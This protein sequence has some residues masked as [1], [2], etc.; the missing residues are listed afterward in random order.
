MQLEKSPSYVGTEKTKRPRKKLDR[1][2]RDAIAAQEAGM[3]YGQ[4]KVQH[5]HTPDEDEEEKKE[6]EIDPDSVVAVCEY[7][8]E[9][10][11]KPKNNKVK[12]FCSA[13]CQNRY[14]TK[15]RTEKARQE[16]IGR[17]ATCPVC[18]TSFIANHHSR[19]YC[20]TEC[21]SKSQRER[22]RDAWERHR[23]KTKKGG[24]QEWNQ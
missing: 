21:F 20:S 11:A 9:Q 7:C 15:K 18:G 24:S 19:I 17:P 16:A 1:L 13:A 6:L 23:E 3:S 8:G 2:T 12:R 22:N 14:N 5:P 4:Y 10:F